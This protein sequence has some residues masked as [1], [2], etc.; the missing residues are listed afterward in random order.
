ME[1]RPLMALQ[2]DP[3]QSD[4]TG[5]LTLSRAYFPSPRMRNRIDLLSHWQTPHIGSLICAVKAITV[6]EAKWTT[7]KPT[8]KE[9]VKQRQ[10]HIL[11]GITQI[12]PR[13]KD[14]KMLEWW[15]PPHS[16]SLTHL[17]HEKTD[18]SWAKPCWNLISAPWNLC[19]WVTSSLRTLY[20]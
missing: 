20:L 2:L 16:H 14:L 19:E 11:G 6:G 13:I 4:P 12:W 10:Y 5:S 3:P 9:K 8:K 15:F 7:S 18:V 17:T 1:V